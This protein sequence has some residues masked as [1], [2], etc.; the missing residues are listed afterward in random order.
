MKRYAIHAALFVA[1]CATTTWLVG[2]V[3]SATLMGILTCHELGHYIAARVR[4]VPASLPYFIPLPFSIGTMGAVITMSEIPDRDALFDV[5]VAGPIAGFVVALPLL[6]IGLVH[7]PLGPI[8]TGDGLEGNS[9]LYALAKYAVF[10]QWLPSRTVDV[11][12]GPMADAAWFGIFITMINLIPIGQLDG[13]HVARALLGNQHE[14]WS[15]RLHIALPVV[16]VVVFAGMLVQALVRGAGVLGAMAYAKDGG[17]PWL[18]WA[19]LLLVLRSRAGGMYHPP[20]TEAPLSPGRR[21][22]AIAVLILFVAIFTP[23]PWR[24][25][26]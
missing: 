4:G 26:L 9:I 20:V 6:V 22:L 19:V 16:G 24:S 13:G 23:V 11:Q 12:L 7:S 15:R 5:G 18:V 25:A 10:G 1:C 17:I 8:H 2:P 3:F 14:R 21:R